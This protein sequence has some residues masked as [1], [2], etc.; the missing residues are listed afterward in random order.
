VV[1]WLSSTPFEA[2]QQL[3]DRFF[4]PVMTQKFETVRLGYFTTAILETNMKNKA[5]F[6]GPLLLSSRPRREVKD[7]TGLSSRRSGGL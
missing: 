7:G 4:S 3:S 1:K 5:V 6:R 2:L